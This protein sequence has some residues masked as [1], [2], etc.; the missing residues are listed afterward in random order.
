MR[1]RGGSNKPCIMHGGRGR[2]CAAAA[3]AILFAVAP[4]AS[5]AAPKRGPDVQDKGVSPVLPLTVAR[6][7]DMRFGRIVVLGGSGQ[8]IMPIDGLPVTTGVVLVGGNMGPARFEIRGEPHRLVD[9]L[10]VDPITG[11]VPPFGNAKLDELEVAADFTRNFR[12][13]PG[14]VQVRL[15]ASGFNAITVG[16]RLSLSPNGSSGFTSVPIPVTASYRN[17]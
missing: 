7:E 4:A 17:E 6:R 16:G 1:L 8:V 5:P 3:A 10:L 9:V 12:Q 2:V 13:Y 15:D 14:S 11:E